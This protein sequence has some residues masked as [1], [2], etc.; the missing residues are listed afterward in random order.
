MFAFKKQGAGRVENKVSSEPQGEAFKRDD[1]DI[2]MAAPKK[3]AMVTAKAD[4]LLSA[5]E[6]TKLTK[7]ISGK[8]SKKK[9]KALKKEAKRLWKKVKKGKASKQ[10]YARLQVV[11]KDLHDKKGLKKLK[12]Y[13]PKNTTTSEAMK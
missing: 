5:K 10:N 9:K 6:E 8:L 7:D 1:A 4:T 11:L 2:D 12:R 13:Q 3:R